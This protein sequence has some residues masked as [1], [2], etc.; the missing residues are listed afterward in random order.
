MVHILETMQL[1][2]TTGK[3]E[4]HNLQVFSSAKKAAAEI[5]QAIRINEGYDQ[6]DAYLGPFEYLVTYKVKK[7]DGTFFT[8]RYRVRKK[9]VK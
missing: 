6:E 3:F 4:P 5:E 1:S 8:V 7:E 9:E 2:R